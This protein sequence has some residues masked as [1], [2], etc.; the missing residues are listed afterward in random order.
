MDVELRRRARGLS[1][2]SSPSWGE[3][4]P[5]PLAKP[6]ARRLRGGEFVLGD[7]AGASLN[8]S[9]E[10]SGAFRVL[11]SVEFCMSLSLGCADMAILG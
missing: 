6:D 1:L 9:F 2:A 11:L 7:F 4:L 3:P 8:G 5:L 10:A